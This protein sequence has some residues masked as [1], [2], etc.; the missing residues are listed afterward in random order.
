[1]KEENWLRIIGYIFNIPFP[2]MM[3]L[4]PDKTVND[5]GKGETDKIISV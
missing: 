2:E 5:S 3:V 1:M 4:Q